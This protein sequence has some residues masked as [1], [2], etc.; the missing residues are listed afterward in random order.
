MDNEIVLYRV[1]SKVPLNIQPGAIKRDAFINHAYKCP[2]LTVANRYG[3]DITCDQDLELE[4]N[5][6]DGKSD[7]TSLRGPG[8]PHFGMGT[9]TL[10]PGYIWRTP[11]DYDLLLLPTPNADQ[12]DFFAMTALLE[13]DWLSYP[14][15]L[16]IM[17]VRPGRLLIPA[18]TPL[19]RVMPVQRLT[20]PVI[21][22][23]E[24]PSDVLEKKE[25]WTRLR[26]ELGDHFSYRRAIERKGRTDGS[27]K[28]E[29]APYYQLP[30]VLTRRCCDQLITDFDPS[31]NGDGFWGG[32]TWWPK[33]WP[34]DVQRVLDKLPLMAERAGVPRG[35]L[36]DPNMVVWPD[37]HKG[38]PLHEDYAN[39]KFSYRDWA[40]VIRLNDNYEG[41]ETFFEDDRE[42]K[43]GVGDALVFRG[44][45]LKH[46]VRG[47][48]G[49][50]RYTLIAWLT[51][52]QA[53]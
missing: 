48:A 49:G 17:F 40:V 41:G 1:T 20:D 46:G 30:N 34:C 9:F 43:L 38:M 19:G 45:S 16:T 12:R 13:T 32:R 47:I 51:E 22:E 25:E 10:T 6:G 2:P 39:G 4:W 15:F 50:D 14:W 27:M 53:T 29:P 36:V 26:R 23:R 8:R 11:K 24:T 28:Q 3:Y 42:V 5:G 7:V 18:S 37:G 21:V 31:P 52:E 35:K 44:G 33:Q